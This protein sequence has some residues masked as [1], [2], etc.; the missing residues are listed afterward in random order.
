[1]ADD[2]P[3]VRAFATEGLKGL[4]YRVLVAEN[5]KQALQIYEQQR[6]E[7]DCVLLDLIMPELSGLETYRRM[8]AVDPAGAGGLRFRLQHRRDSARRSRRALGGVHW[9]ALYAGRAF[10]R[11][12]QGGDGPTAL[13]VRCRS[14]E[15]EVPGGG[16]QAGG[17]GKG[18][19][20]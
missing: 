1:M 13:W 8:R 12:A 16:S 2:E 7:I 18:S 6:Q 3:L 20:P 10:P 19:L 15:T 11:A 9:E 17:D 5:G 14:W 4:G